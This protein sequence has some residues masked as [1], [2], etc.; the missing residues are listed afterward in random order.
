[1]CWCLY[2]VQF[3][4]VSLTG[5]KWPRSESV[6]HTGVEGKREAKR[7]WVKHGPHDMDMA[8]WG[9]IHMR[10]SRLETPAWSQQSYRKNFLQ[11][12][13]VR[14]TRNTDSPPACHSL[15]PHRLPPSFYNQREY[16]TPQHKCS[17]SSDCVSTRIR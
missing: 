16:K 14:R 5:S 6:N 4:P 15:A 10:R 2:A 3:L 7:N 12:Y 8:T 1:M 17:T 9:L 11:L 13:Q